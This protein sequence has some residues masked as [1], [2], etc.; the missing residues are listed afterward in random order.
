M[1]Q[2]VAILTVRVQGAKLMQ[3]NRNP[4]PKSKLGWGG[5]SSFDVSIVMVKLQLR[6]SCKPNDAQLAGHDDDDAENECDYEGGINCYW[7]EDS[8]YAPDSDSDW[9]DG[10][11]SLVESNRALGYTGNSI[12]MAQRNAK[13][14]RDREREQ[15]AAKKS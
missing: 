15:I 14:A 5:R 10:D 11:E 8:D 12:R 1:S 9:S 6:V 2:S 13:A 7:S 4:N 3:K